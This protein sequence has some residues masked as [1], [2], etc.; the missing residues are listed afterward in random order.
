MR[1]QCCPI[2]TVAILIDPC[3]PQDSDGDGDRWMYIQSW[4][5][6]TY[7]PRASGIQYHPVSH[8]AQEEIGQGRCVDGTEW[9]WLTRIP[10]DTIVE[11]TVT[12]QP[13][14]YTAPLQPLAQSPPHW[15]T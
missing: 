9:G 3:Q 8:R 5:I 10:A 13:I 12:T 1:S 11:A 4:S 7:C 14:G 15:L 2:A 6:A